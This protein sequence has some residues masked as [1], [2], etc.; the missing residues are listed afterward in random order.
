M[1][2]HFTL[3]DDRSLTMMTIGAE[4]L[5]IALQQQLFVTVPFGADGQFPVSLAFRLPT[6]TQHPL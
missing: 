3:E 4:S 2:E 1:Y 6:P 5:I